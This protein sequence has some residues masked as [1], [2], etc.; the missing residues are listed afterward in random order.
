MTCWAELSRHPPASWAGGG[1]LSAL[2]PWR[3]PDALTLL[4]R[5]AGQAYSA[6]EYELQQQGFPSL[7]VEQSGLLMPGVADAA[8]ALMWAQRWNLPAEVVSASRICHRYLDDHAVWMPTLGQLRNPRAMKTLSASLAAGGVVRVTDRIESFERQGSKWLL[9]GRC[10]QA[11]YHQL[12]LCTGAGTPGLVQRSTGRRL[13]MFPAR[14]EMLCYAPG[15]APPPCIILREQGYVIPRADGT[16]LVGSTLVES[17]DGRPTQRGS[18]ALM[19]LAES[20]W[21][22]LAGRVPFAHWAGI[23]PG[24]R[25]P[26]PILSEL[27]EAPGVFIASG[28]FRNGL[29]AAPASA[30]LITALM[31]GTAAPFD[32]APY[33]LS[34]SSSPP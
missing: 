20:L 2:F 21:P 34:S 18:G 32:P 9:R 6:L 31:T 16:L 13:P 10:H 7:G 5:H 1:I 12:L 17:P 19:R 4:T 25:A 28:H 29:V 8:E 11:A 3:F 30:A 27:P 33:A 24:C 23:R 15:V 14:G 26:V 22:P